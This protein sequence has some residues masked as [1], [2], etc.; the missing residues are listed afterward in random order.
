M[1]SLFLIDFSPEFDYVYWPIGCGCLYFLEFS[2]IL[3][4]SLVL[5]FYS[6]CMNVL[7]AMI[8]PVTTA[9]IVSLKFGYVVSSL[10]I[11]SLPQW[12]LH[13]KL[14]SFYEYI[15]VLLLCCCWSPT[16]IHGDLI[17]CKGLFQMSD[18]CWG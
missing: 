6:F 12:L 11:S 3:F 5:L 7:S 15:C 9:F 18:T 8:F 4:D 10:F 13:S 17:G 14:F 2:G 1:F 16:L